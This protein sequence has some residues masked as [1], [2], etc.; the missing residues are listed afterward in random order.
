MFNLIMYALCLLMSMTGCAMKSQGLSGEGSYLKKD[1]H[2]YSGILRNGVR[3]FVRQNHE[4]KKHIELRLTLN[5]GSLQENKNQLG[6]AHFLEHLAFNGTEHFSKQAMTD[7]IQKQG[8]DMGHGVNASTTLDTT[9]YRLRLLHDDEKSFDRALL[10]LRD[11]AE[12]ITV[13]EKSF[14]NER[15]IVLEEIRQRKG[16]SDRLQRETMPFVLGEKYAQRPSGD[17]EVIKLWTR[18][19]VQKFYRDWYRPEFMAVVIVGD[20]VPVSV[21][22]KIKHLF[23]NI[24]PKTSMLTH[25]L[26]PMYVHDDLK[27]KSFLDPEYGQAMIHVYEK[28]DVPLQKMT[29]EDVRQELKHALYFSML[30]Q[31]LNVLALNQRP[32]LRAQAY[33]G[34]FNHL[35]SLN[36][37]VIKVKKQRYL[38]G[39]QF[40]FLELVRIAQ[41][42]FLLSEFQRAK[43]NKLNQ[44]IRNDDQTATESSVNYAQRYS[45]DAFHRVTHVSDAQMYPLL[46]SLLE[47]LTLADINAMPT[48]F[49]Q[50][51]NTTISLLGS[52][53]LESSIPTSSDITAMLSKIKGR[54]KIDLYQ[55]DMRHDP[56]VSCLLPKGH[57]VSEIFHQKTGITELKLSNGAKVLLKP[58][59]LEKR[60][61]LFHAYSKGGLVRAGSQYRAAEMLMGRV[62]SA[63]GLG[64]FSASQ[65]KKKVHAKESSIYPYVDL[66]HEGVRGYTTT[67][68]IETLLQLNYLYFT[69]SRVD[70]AVYE[71]IK[72]SVVGEMLLNESS[73][74]NKFW[75]AIVENTI[76]KNSF[77]HELSV[78]EVQ[79]SRPQDLRD[80]LVN[81]FVNAGDFR[82]Q[83]VGDFKVEEMKPLIEKY[84]ANLPA[85]DRRETYQWVRI[86]SKDGKHRITVHEALEYK[87]MVLIQLQGHELYRRDTKKRFALLKRILSKKIRDTLREE[88]GLIYS[89]GIQYEL[90]KLGE[91]YSA[92][93]FFLQCDPDHVQKV[94]QGWTH[95][96][97]MLKLEPI[98]GDENDPSE[99]VS[100]A[101]LDSF[102]K[103]KKSNQKQ[104]KSNGYWA[105]KMFDLY[106]F[107]LPADHFPK[108]KK[109]VK[110][111]PKAI[112]HYARQYL[113]M[114]N[115]IIAVLNPKKDITP[116]PLP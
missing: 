98:T 71:D 100:Q 24:S 84:I 7:F 6:M 49:M 61:V 22:K 38:E 104:R 9:E 112:A 81:R 8:V 91:P 80:L 111:T 21:V 114:D 31:R 69:K 57:I 33:Q 27:I 94:I 92:F 65:L 113:N 13:D 41:H 1:P 39:L 63:S 87:S 20:V 105:K 79:Q 45:H 53:T 34:R 60:E 102:K 10:L 44:I 115:V 11:W 58:T 3:Y 28:V 77:S 48:P 15:L 82:F 42:G 83:F 55:D 50:Q 85:N 90:A 107:N 99:F 96:V 14:D 110:Y 74:G 89:V 12:N 52:E 56:L 116:M 95:V 78:E 40:V 75:K 97:K 19:D 70:D 93:S 26:P 51:K 101:M 16:V 17:E 67:N 76:P 43:Q 32:Y 25:Q 66:Y 73:S 88:Q 72:A 54:K 35:F 46:T 109:S 86:H 47:E 68:N 108:S 30:R 18:E 106:V 4:P 36:S 29:V 2:L 64:V 103:A 37:I 23:S 59:K 5:V 62:L